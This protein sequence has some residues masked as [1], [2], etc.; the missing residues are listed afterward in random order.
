MLSKPIESMH[1]K[2]FHLLLYKKLNIIRECSILNEH[3]IH[4][5]DSAKR[6]LL[7]LFN[8]VLQ[9]TCVPNDWQTSII[10]PIYKVKGKT[11]SDPSS[12]R[13]IALIPVVSRLFE[14]LIL[15][16]IVKFL[17]TN[18]VNLPNPQQQGFQPNLSCLTT[19]LRLLY[20][21]LS[22]IT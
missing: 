3:I 6:M 18:F 14:N 15:G 4:G 10:I 7:V 12:Y 1:V 8:S 5:G 16:R 9:N 20:K 17:K 19:A 13:S 21:K 22:C 2:L 11:K